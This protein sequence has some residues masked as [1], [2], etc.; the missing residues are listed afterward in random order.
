MK[1]EISTIRNLGKICVPKDEGGIS[2]R[3]MHDISKT[4]VIKRW[5]RV[6]AR[7][8]VEPSTFWTINSG[9]CDM[10]G[11]LVRKRALGILYPDHVHNNNAKV[12]DYIDGDNQNMDKLRED[13]PE[14]IVLYIANI[15]IGDANEN[16]C[17]LWNITVTTRDYPW[18]P[19]GAYDPERP[20]ANT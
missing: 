3:N 14:R 4:L 13:L 11:Q 12:M 16:D 20:Q 10:V 6:N 2:I 18:S 17:A 9:S 15:P 5:G 8:V 19:H 1:P 7:E